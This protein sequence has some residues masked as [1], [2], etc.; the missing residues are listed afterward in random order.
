MFCDNY[1]EDLETLQYLSSQ[2][3]RKI[4]VSHKLPKVN[5]LC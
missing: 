1:S 5:H 2:P 4:Q 3:K